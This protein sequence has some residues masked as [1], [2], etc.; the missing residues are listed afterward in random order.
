MVVTKEA[1]TLRG[2]YLRSDFTAPFGTSPFKG[3]VKP[4]RPEDFI[5]AGVVLPVGRAFHTATALPEGDVLVAGGQDYAGNPLS[6][7]CIYRAATGTFET[8]APLQ[9]ARTMHA[10]VPSRT[11]GVMVLGGYG[12]TGSTLSSVEVYDP[13]ANTWTAVPPMTRSRTNHT[14][15]VVSGARIL[16]VGGFTNASGSLDYAPGAEIYNPI[17]G[18][19]TATTGATLADR[20]GHTATV[21]PD[22]RVLIVGGNRA[23]IRTSELY[24][25]ATDSFQ[26]TGLPSVERT[27]HAACLTKSGT[28]LIAGGGPGLAEQYDP[29]SNAFTPAGTCPPVGL[30]VV[31]S[32][33]FASL[34]LVP[35]GGRIALLGGLEIG[36]GVCG[37]GPR[38]PP[39]PGSWPPAQRGARGRAA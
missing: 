33:L 36:G 8:V 11:G 19:W 1:R 15:T 7:C 29:S 20:G 23:G 24:V 25:S 38:P 21:L 10:A 16:V 6:S 12:P 5:A 39:V 3:G 18:A 31:T 28:V 34:T 22:G 2:R 27:F 30:P 4:L 35:G 37:A 14:A 9:V 26:A 13:F 32:P 17:T